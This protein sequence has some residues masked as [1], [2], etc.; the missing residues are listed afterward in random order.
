MSIVIAYLTTREGLAALRRARLEAVA[1]KAN[2]LVSDS[3]SE[4]QRSESPEVTSFEKELDETRTALAEHGLTVEIRTYSAVEQTDPL[5]SLAEEVD[6][7]FII[8]GIRRRSPVG[9]L[10]MGSKAQRILLDAKC[11]VL[12]VKASETDD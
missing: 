6:A 5:L 12:A 2:L 8:I 9:K 7:D 3:R 10:V 11:A 1:H 4:S